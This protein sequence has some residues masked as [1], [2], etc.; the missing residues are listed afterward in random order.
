MHI[1]IT[2][3]LGYNPFQIYHIGNRDAKQYRLSLKLQPEQ[4]SNFVQYGSKMWAEVGLCKWW[5]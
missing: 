4:T 3:N 1:Y 2:H 5:L